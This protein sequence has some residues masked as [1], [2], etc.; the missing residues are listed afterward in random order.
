MDTCIL[1]PTSSIYYN[2]WEPHIILL[3]KFWN[4]CKF[5][6][7]MGSD[8]YF[9]NSENLDKKYNFTY[10][11]TEI[12]SKSN[13]IL[14]RLLY[15]VE[16]LKKKFNKIIII[17][18]DFFLVRKVNSN[19]IDNCIKLM[20]KDSKIGSIQL[21]PSPSGKKK[22]IYNSIKFEGTINQNEYIDYICSHCLD[23]LYIPPPNLYLPHIDADLEDSRIKT[24]HKKVNKINLCTTTA[25]VVQ[26]RIW[27]IDFLISGLKKL[28]N[29]GKKILKI[30][31][32]KN[33]DITVKDIVLLEVIGPYIFKEKKILVP[34]NRWDIIYPTRGFCGGGI[35]RGKASKWVLQLME[36]HNIKFQLFNGSYVYD[37]NKYTSDYKNYI[38][39]KNALYAEKKI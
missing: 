32:E 16:L 13:N 6:I 22:N 20:R 29:P 5:P 24:N 7:Y 11:I 4:D 34:E 1:I 27:D 3:K 37:L 25:T 35:F 33:I 14:N 23:K 28:I 30:C 39:G 12:E 19:D 38:L 21:H 31:N 15:Y 9:D 18:D 36:K 17:I 8:K 10:L 2:V 26:P